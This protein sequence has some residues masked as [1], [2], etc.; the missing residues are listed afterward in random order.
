MKA[1][2][3]F[4]HQL[5]EKLPFSS[6]NISLVFLYEDP[7]FFTQFAFH[8]MKLAFHKASM[9][10]YENLLKKKGFRVVVIPFTGGEEELKKQIK[11]QNISS[12]SVID[13]ADD[14]AMRN[15]QK[16][17][18]SSTA[19]ASYPSPSFLLS[20]E[21][22]L[23][24]LGDKRTYRF[25]DFYKK[26]RH[27]LGVLIDS[28]A[29]PEGGQY[30]FDS[31]NRKRMP[32][33]HK[34][35]ALLRL[36]SAKTWL[37]SLEWVEKN[38]SK[39]PGGFELVYPTDHSQAQSWL[40]DF[41]V[42]KLS[43][44]GPY[45]DFIS[46]S[47]PFIY[48]SLLSPLLN[49]GLITPHEVLNSALKGKSIPLPSLEGFLRQVIGWREFI[50]AVYVKAGRKERTCN[51]FNHNR[52]LPKSFWEGTTGIDPVDH[53]IQNVL[54]TGYC[55][56]IE[57]LMVLGCFM[58][59]CEIDPD[60]VYA[61]FME[62][63]IDAY[64]WVMVPNVYGMSQFADGGLFAT[65]PYICGSNYILKMSDHKKG[66]W[67]EVWDG[68]YWRFIDKHRKLFLTNHRSSMLVKTLD[69]M[70]LD[71]KKRIFDAAETFLA[72]LV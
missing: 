53:A 69:K 40:E 59:L 25:A 72:N 16:A 47:E 50:R 36:S 45:E 71:R 13:P 42:H 68:L 8:K 60:A 4:P 9:E 33:G 29:E 31:E 20:K 58:L 17:L 6:S 44:F 32:K 41:V 5:F 49:S 28:N 18:E 67:C 66:P 2:L 62:L 1:A 37:D 52:K 38:F 63:F 65:K 51:F 21:E 11:V 10:A 19:I 64:D 46:T 43:T 35:P 15:I 26:M 56:H 48:H 34:P 61:W 24:F 54:K 30:S 70:D 14:Y 39:N 23:H 3:L 12:L 22:A 57:R 27:K 7:L 55:H